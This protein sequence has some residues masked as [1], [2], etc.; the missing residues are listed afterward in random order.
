MLLLLAQLVAPPLQPGPVRI[1]EPVPKEQFPS[2]PVDQVP[3]DPESLQLPLKAQPSKQKGGPTA[4]WR[5][6]IEGS[7]PYSSDELSDILSICSKSSSA[8]RLQSCAEAI[9][10]RLQLDGYVNSRVF[11]EEEPSPGRLVVV[12]GRL[13]ELQ[14]EASTP[15]LEQRVR[16]ALSN[17]I[18]E[19][20]QLPVL[21]SR[22]RQLKQQNVVGSIS[23]TLGKLGSDPTQGVLRIT[24]TAPMHPW[25]GD[26]SLRNDGNA[27][28][29]EWRAITILQK[30]NIFTDGDLLQ[31][32]GE[33]NVDSDPEFG[34]AIGSL[35]YTFPLAS[36]VNF[37]GSFGAS[38]RNFV[39]VSGLAHGL[40]FRQYQGLGQLQWT[41]AE[42]VHHS[43]YA[44]AGLS[45][46]HKNSYL[47]DQSFPL[48]IGGGL[49]GDLTTGY[50]RFGLGNAGRYGSWSWSGQVYGLQGLAGFS[51]SD[52]LSNL[53]FF[54]VNPG[55]SRALGGIMTNGWSLSRTLQLSLRVAGQISFNEL[56]NDMGFSLGSDTG[57]RGLPGSL[58]S[59]DDGWLANTEFSWTF[60]QK[61]Q[62]ALQ[63]VP[64]LGIG[65]ISTRRDDI[66]ISDTIGSGGMLLRW[67]NGQHWNV[68]LGWIDQF[69][70]EN[71]IGVWND[72]ILGSGLY[73]KVSFRF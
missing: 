10:A 6:T 51:T 31:L 53:A 28:S 66:T 54:G 39:E 52:E 12:T 64:F 56:T 4:P 29:G 3:L 2:P 62:N 55:E 67:L 20:L 22:L 37:T 69:N 25:R 48:I 7:A 36:N 65:G 11:V 23:G 72:W 58:I 38:R 45:S 17:L 27:G 47:N 30:Q 42:N 16:A 9:T 50:L 73:G 1:P 71:N 46:N 5:P 8:L 24:V 63:L 14:V 35:S 43:C 44:F 41:F 59:G 34:A 61:D 49:D 18:Q 32:Y 19:P 68:E 13:V 70:A 33:G 26:L 60:W 15:S 21:Q 57:L 40:S